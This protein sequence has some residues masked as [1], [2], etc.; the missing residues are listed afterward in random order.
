MNI[1]PQRTLWQMKVPP[2][3]DSC[4]LESF[5]PESSLW[6]WGQ[7][8]PL[9]TPQCSGGPGPVS[10]FKQCL[11]ES[12]LKGCPA[13]YPP[14]HPGLRPKPEFSNSPDANEKRKEGA[15]K[16]HACTIPQLCVHLV[17]SSSYVHRPTCSGSQCGELRRPAPLTP[18]PPTWISKKVLELSVS[19]KIL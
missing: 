6:K 13:P 18:R 10:Y 3:S 11:Q 9:P 2:W 19:L 4:L 16:A 5:K 15:V 14:R 17:L 7:S 8:A 1:Q 12:V